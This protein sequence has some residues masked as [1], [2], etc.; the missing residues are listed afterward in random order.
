MKP[1]FALAAVLAF[2]LLCPLHSDAGEGFLDAG[3]GSVD[4]TPTEPVVLAGSPSRLKSTSISSRLYA[5]ALVLS[6]GK[7]KVAIVTLDTLKYPVEHSE[8]ARRQIEKTTGIPAANVI[9]CSSHTHSGPLWSYYDDQLV[10][11][12]AEAVAIAVRDLSPCKFGMA[13]CKAEGISEC[14][15]VI[16]EGHAWN[17]WQLK[18]EERDQFPAEGP[19]DP[20]FDVLALMGEDQKWKAVVYNFACHAANT[21]DLSVSADFPGEVQKYVTKQVGY[22]VPSLF[23]CGAAG[24][25]NPIY[26]VKEEVFGQKLGSEIVRGLAELQFIAKPALS[27]ETREFPMAGRENPQLQE[28]EITRNWP[29]QLE[30]YKKS[31][32]DMKQRAQANYPYFITGIRIGD[33]FAIV[34]NANE[35]FCG[36]AMSIKKQSP[37]KYTMT[38]QQTNGAHGYVPTA[39]AFEGGSYETW[40]GEHSYLTP[41]AGEIIEKES[42]EILK[43]LK[44][45]K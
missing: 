41:R 33:D 5:R 27:L 38:V 28:A 23:L 43:R 13:K 9:I 15:R 45:S 29:A 31:F 30:H 11:P 6:D 26:S 19:A 16:K 7:Q 39:K 44:P 2:L 36:I 20:E 24:D 8:R 25:I 22:E 32:A 14:R 37:F 18:P 34:T 42:L 10:T 4:I 35:L 3:I 21:R 40:F 1:N 12:I 17:R